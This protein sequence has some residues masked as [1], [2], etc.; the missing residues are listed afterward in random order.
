M[1]APAPREGWMAALLLVYVLLL[2]GG[3]HFAS[4]GL[5]ERDGYYHARLANQFFERGLSREFPWTQASTWREG[6]CDKEFL[7]HALMAPFCTNDAEPVRGALVLQ[8]LLAALVVGMLWFV[9][10]KQDVPH[11]WAF[12]ALL[13]VMGVPV[14][15]RMAMVRSHVLSMALAVFGMHL[16]Y[17]QRW[18]ALLALGFVYAWSYTFP[19][20]LV[21]FAAPYVVGHWVGGGRLD[22]RSPLAAFA[23]VMLGLV[24]HPYSPQTLETFATILEIVRMG[25]SGRR[26][27]ELELG[28]EIYAYSTRAFLLAFPVW[29]AGMAAVTLCGWRLGRRLTP[30]AFGAL[31]A[32]LA[33][34]AMT[35]TFSRF[36]EYGA[37]LACLAFGLIARDAWAA[38]AAP[39]EAP[40]IE[41]PP[42]DTPRRGGMAGLMRK[43]AAA[44]VLLLVVSAHAWIAYV[45]VRESMKCPPPRFRAASAWMA[46]HLE[47]GETVVNL[48][49]DD[50]PDLYYDG[51]RQRY[52]WGIDP[53]F[54]L[55]LEPNGEGLAKLLEDMRAGRV[56]L[57]GAVLRKVFGAR[58]MAVRK[59]A[60]AGSI[61][62]G[63]R[64][65]RG[66]YRDDDAV[67]FWLQDDPQ[68]GRP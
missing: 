7:Y 47:P 53:T 57:D 64:N 33:W 49:W 56:P 22:W 4:P 32:A 44:A 14:L 24:V 21:M 38:N 67:L 6:Y 62:K 28:K 65:V 10:R 61:E 34:L 8:T 11:A 35:M 60:L 40:Q 9:L 54:T 18:K 43:D 19:M 31:F 15:Y 46:E 12:A 59:Q 68:G 36:M 25:F 1:N 66:A 37:P 26:H 50:F 27:A 39:Q 29:L 30:Q 3:V 48:W 2:F 42:K 41:T 58:V 45:F 23:G 5:S 51:Y 13:L 16:L 17:R 63:L 20:V 52:L 55:R